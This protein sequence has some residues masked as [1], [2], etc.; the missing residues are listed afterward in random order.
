[1]NCTEQKIGPLD[2]IVIDGGQSPSIAVVLCHGYGASLRD[3]APIGA[4]WVE[5]LGDDASKFRFVFPNAPES[6][7]EMGMPESR[8]WWPLNMARLFEMV[9]ASRFEELHDETPPGMT[10][11]TDLLVETVQKVLAGLGAN[12]PRLVLGGFSQ[13]AMVTMNAALTATDEKGHPSIAPEVLLQFS[14]TVV[15]RAQWQVAIPSRLAKTWVYQSHGTMDPV[16]PF[17]SAETL[18]DMMRS[19]ETD[20]RFHSF[21]GP[22]TIDTDTIAHIAES[23]KEMV[24]S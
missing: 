5:M 1:M 22:H 3:L 8:A 15:C 11:A 12:S 20:L 13:G 18:R 14:G 4:Q 10:E 7:A 23:L 2:C 9:Q 24:Q 21:A 19:S 6:L 17:S 16:L